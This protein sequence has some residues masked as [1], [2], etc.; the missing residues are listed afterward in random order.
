MITKAVLVQRKA[1]KTA[2]E[3]LKVTIE[4]GRVTGLTI[5]AGDKS[6]S[7]DLFE[8]LS[9]SFNKITVEYTPQGTDGQG[10]G[11]MMFADQF[12]ELA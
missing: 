6:G 9:F 12:D 3:F 2:L 1:G 4:Q 7:P 10:K 11:G 5:E 8:N